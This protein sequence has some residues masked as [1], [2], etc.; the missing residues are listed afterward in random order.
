[1]YDVKTD[2][3]GDAA[4]AAYFVAGVPIEDVQRQ[5]CAVLV[6]L[7]DFFEQHGIRYWL[8]GGTL[9]GALRHGGFIPWDDDIDIV[10]ARPDYE[11]LLTLLD[12]LP[13]SLRPI[14]PQNCPTTPF[15]FLVVTHAQSHLV[16]DY[17]KP[18]D[19]GIG[20]DVFP[21]DAIPAPGWRR[22]LLFRAVRLMRSLS[23]NKQQGFYPRPL[24]GNVQLR[25]ALLSALS[26]ILS[27][28]TIFTL[29]DKIVGHGDV[30]SSEWVGNLYGVYGEREV[31]KREIFG[32][33]EVRAPFAAHALRVP[34]QPER[35]LE[36]IYG[37]YMK[38][39]P[40]EKRNTEHR[41]KFVAIGDDKPAS[42]SRSPSQP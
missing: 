7:T 1:M 11:R 42:P 31:V 3:T 21:L 15:P 19:R 13:D 22:Q 25:F 30:D 34:A 8:V 9:L 10:V 27:A 32:S 29:Y 4:E 39:P 2:P 33:K 18:F 26:N 17:K 28:R 23:M 38:L 6:S 12:S 5:A 20:I 41:I 24:N 37:D 16:M 35:Y 40:L 36:N 14:H